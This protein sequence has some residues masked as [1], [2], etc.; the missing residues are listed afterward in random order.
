MNMITYEDRY[1]KVDAF[2]MGIDYERFAKQIDDPVYHKEVEEINSSTQGQKMILSIDRLDYT[3]GI[4]GRIRAFETLLK[5]YPEYVGKVRLNL[6][7]A[8]SRIEVDRYENLRREI[9]ELVSELNGKYG[10]IG[11]MPVWFF[12]QSFSQERLIAYYRYADVLI[13]TPLR[14][15]MNLVAKE[16]I[17]ARTDYRGMVV[18]SETAGAASELGEA[19]VVNPNDTE[20]VARGLKAALEMP[21]EEKETINRIIHKRL[22]RYNVDFWA[23]DFINEL[24][25]VAGFSVY[26]KKRNIW[27]E[28]AKIEDAYRKACHRLLFLDYDGTLVGFTARPNEA[29]PDA[30]LLNLLEQLTSDK[31]NTVVIISGRDRHTIK[32]WLDSPNLHILASH[33]LWIHHPDKEWEKTVEIDNSWK[34]SIAGLLEIYADRMPGAIIEEKEFA[35]AFH[36]RQCEPDMVEQKLS[37]VR[38]ALMSMTNSMSIGIQEGNKVLEIKDASVNKGLGASLYLGSTDYDFILGIGDDRTDEDLFNALPQKAFSIKVGIGNTNADYY[39]KSWESVRALLMSLSQ[40]NP[41]S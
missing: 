20:A 37:E 28:H 30:D 35:L 41:Q 3:K 7:V 26:K 27:K 14:D 15:G 4:P 10:S 25:N 32:K 1:V 34:K 17:A 9:T 36:Y 39:I 19:V 24:H 2:P 31:M 12:F 11:W 5:N 6:I 21:D 40:S 33:G 23:K 22:K 38:E 13:V 18:I 16:Y 8:P 29:K